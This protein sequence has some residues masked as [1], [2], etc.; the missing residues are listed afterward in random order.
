MNRTTWKTLHPIVACAAMG[1][2]A[3]FWFSSLLSELFASHDTV[4]LVKQSILYAFCLFIPCMALTGISGAKLAGK[5]KNPL[6]VAKR[7][8]MP[9]I[10][11]NGIVILIPCAVFLFIKAR[12]GEFDGVFYSVQI[13]E[14][15]AGGVNFCLMAKNARDARQLFR[16]KS[17]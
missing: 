14:L 17:A 11:L 8:R 16:K 15:I 7:R 5:S 2:I 9:L 3:C 1:F 10:A 4:L 6:I 12:A 13:L